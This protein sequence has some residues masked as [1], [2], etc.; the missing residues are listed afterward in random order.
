[1]RIA[2]RASYLCQASASHSKLKDGEDP[3]LVAEMLVRIWRKQGMTSLQCQ[4]MLDEWIVKNENVNTKLS[5]NI[6]N[7][8][9]DHNLSPFSCN[10]EVMSN[11]CDSACTLFSQRFKEDECVIHSLDT[12]VDNAVYSIKKGNQN[13]ADFNTLFDTVHY[14]FYRGEVLV[15]VGPEKAG[16][17]SFIHNWFLS[18]KETKPK[19]LNIHL[20][21]Q[22]TL[23]ISRLI[24]IDKQ[25]EVNATKNVDEVRDY[26]IGK[27]DLNKFKSNY[28][29]IEFYNASRSAPDL[30]KIINENKY[31]IVYIDSF[32]TIQYKGKAISETMSQKELIGE[33]QH[34][35]RLNNFF[36]ILIHHQ[37][38]LGDENHITT[39]SVSGVKE[40]VYQADHII[41]LE[42]VKNYPSQRRLRKLKSRRH[43]DFCH[44][45]HGNGN[46]LTWQ[47][48]S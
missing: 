4:V 15:F 3:D 44:I 1:M 30:I 12:M 18:M 17:T 34:L 10:S 37:N 36:L 2:K 9:F 45:L 41:A 14:P 38:K 5:L 28:D 39:N 6:I 23:E 33:F 32:D 40:I 47:L 29:Y 42:N 25:L 48:Y 46:T 21:M 19:L 7:K 24:Q 11:H 31:D 13:I 22:G 20:E 35:A 16:K 26:I 8:V 27:K 43:G